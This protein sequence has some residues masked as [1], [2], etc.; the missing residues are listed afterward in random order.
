MLGVGCYSATCGLITKPMNSQFIKILIH[1]TI[2]QG[3]KSMVPCLDILSFLPWI[4][5]HVSLSGKEAV[6]FKFNH[7][8]VFPN[9]KCHNQVQHKQRDDCDGL[10][11]QG[12][13]L[14]LQY[15]SIIEPFYFYFWGLAENICFT[16]PAWTRMAVSSAL[17]TIHLC[18]AQATAVSTTE[19]QHHPLAWWTTSSL[20][21]LPSILMNLCLYC[22]FE[23]NSSFL[24][25]RV[26]LLSKWTAA[27]IPP[28]HLH[29][30]HNP[31]CWE[32]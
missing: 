1:I 10:P 7:C 31:L 20:H 6:T 28:P 9:T 5:K 4:Y 8:I 21:Y 24:V 23:R 27:S 22:V 17:T 26:M 30:W 25:C 11:S 2:I 15:T 14:L 32:S 3:E 18:S 16:C 12:S 19:D 13:I 29:V